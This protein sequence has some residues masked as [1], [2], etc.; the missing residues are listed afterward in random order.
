MRYPFSLLTL[1]VLG[2][3]PLTWSLR[4]A[5]PVV[6][7]EAAGAEV[8][9]KAMDYAFEV[10]ETVRPGR[11]TIR[12]VNRGKELHHVWI[13]KLEEG[14]GIGDLL[15][16]LKPGTPFPTWAKNIGG[17]NASVPGG[18]AVGIV[19]LPEGSYAVVCFIPSPDGMPHIMK[20][21]V[22]PLIV[23]GEPVAAAA[24]EPTAK[25]VLSDYAFTFAKPIAPGRQVI[26]FTNASGQTHEAFLAKLLPGKHAA[27]LLAWV[28]KM[29]GPPPAIPM[30]GI[31]GIEPGAVQSVIVDF[32][33]GTYAWFCFVPDAKDGK[34]HVHHGMVREFTVGAVNA[35]VPAG[36]QHGAGHDRKG[37]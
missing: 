9:I 19:D 12:L 33:P 15:G 4:T 30:S 32:E 14:K 16:A 28:A 5:A 2:G 24:I 11:R 6:G 22:K 27:D 10:P 18:D 17:P 23:S 7:E 31:T 35:A 37:H 20:G 36:S 3:V 21:M 8:V 1:L 25:A 34:E 13:V 29:D 26:E